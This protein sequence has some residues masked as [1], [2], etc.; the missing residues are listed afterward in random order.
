MGIYNASLNLGLYWVE[1]DMLGRKISFINPGNPK[2]RPIRFMVVDDEEAHRKIAQKGWFLPEFVGH[3]TGK[4]NN[5]LRP[6]EVYE[7]GSVEDFLS[8]ME[9]PRKYLAKLEESKKLASFLGFKETP[10]EY[11]GRTKAQTDSAFDFLL[12]DIRMDKVTEVGKG[13]M[14]GLDAVVRI[15]TER[16]REQPNPHFMGFPVVLL[17]AYGNQLDPSR[18]KTVSRADGIIS[19]PVDTDSFKDAAIK[20]LDGNF[21]DP[22]NGRNYFNDRYKMK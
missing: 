5:E 13:R 4:N 8:L 18:S 21:I 15:S 22:T 3:A 14:D 9:D 6:V 1:S 17:T 20:F 2:N 10:E 12:L 16:A 11:I 7:A 19:K